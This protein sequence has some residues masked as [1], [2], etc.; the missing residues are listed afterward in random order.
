MESDGNIAALFAESDF[1]S[2]EGIE[3]IVLSTKEMCVE[4]GN[5]LSDELEIVLDEPIVEA[6][7]N[8]LPKYRCGKIKK[9]NSET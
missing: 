5:Y 9:D 4:F 1:N 3:T 6:V 7:H 2:N 8:G